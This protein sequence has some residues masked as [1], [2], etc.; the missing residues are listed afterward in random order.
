MKLWA[1]RLKENNISIF[2]KDKL[3]ASPPGLL[4]HEDHLILCIQTRYQMD[5]FRRLGNRFIGIDATH[6]TT[7]YKD[8]MLYTMIARDDWGHGASVTFRLWAPRLHL[9][10]RRP[11]RVDGF[12]IDEKGSGRFLSQL[13]E[14]SESRHS[15]INH[16]VRS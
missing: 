2:Y 1:E 8:I 3:D 6:N 9:A 5:A 16:H 12:V 4:M 13:G 10:Y 15:A 11:G 7:Q 14:R